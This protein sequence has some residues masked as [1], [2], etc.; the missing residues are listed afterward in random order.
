MRGGCFFDRGWDQMGD[1]DDPE[2]DDEAWGSKRG[3]VG[4][5]VFRVTYAGAAWMPFGGLRLR[6]YLGFVFQHES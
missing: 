1:E 3:G 5:V 6:L 2:S 4:E